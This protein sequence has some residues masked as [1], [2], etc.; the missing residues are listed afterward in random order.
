MTDALGRDWQCGTLQVD[1]VLPDRLGSTYINDMGEKHTPVMLHRAILGSFERFI[2]ILLENTSGRLPFWLA[3]TQIVIASITTN[4]EHYVEEI[5]VSFKNV[6]LRCIVDNRNE[7]INYKVREHSV[8]KIPIIAVVGEKELKTRS[9]NIRRLGQKS[10]ETMSL[11]DAV[12]ELSIEATPPD[13][14]MK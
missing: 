13:K 2:G 14:K 7:K 12:S 3:P 10:S 5:A 4:M 1:F 9:I 11:N 8:S 6:G